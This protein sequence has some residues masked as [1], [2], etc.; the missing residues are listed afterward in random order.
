[1][2][3]RTKD[4]YSVEVGP[5]GR[6]SRQPRRTVA[7]CPYHGYYVADVRGVSELEKYFRY[8]SWRKP[9]RGPMLSAAP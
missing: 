2:K 3:Y 4:G 9:Y 8:P 7:A 6:Y 5:A 1:M